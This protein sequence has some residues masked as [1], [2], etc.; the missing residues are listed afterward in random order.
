MSDEEH[1]LVQAIKEAAYSDLNHLAQHYAQTEGLENCIPIMQPDNVRQTIRLALEKISEICVSVM[2]SLYEDKEGEVPDTKTIRKLRPSVRL[3]DDVVNLMASNIRRI[4]LEIST[5]ESRFQQFL[6]S[7]DQHSESS[8]S[9]AYGAGTIG[10]IV[11]GLLGGPIGAL[12]GGAAAGAWSGHSSGE[13]LQSEGHNLCS[14]F[15]KLIES[16]ESYLETVA[17]K[18]LDAVVNY[19]DQLD[20][21]AQNNRLDN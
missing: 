3:R 1:P 5:Y 16:A 9:Q 7:Y 15:C 10:G 4:E 19:S 12:I 13:N 17:E 2:E 14:A 20:A 11:G 21:A 18:A 8:N 6:R